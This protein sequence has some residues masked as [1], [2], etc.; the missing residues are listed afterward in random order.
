MTVQAGV[1]DHQI[2]DAVALAMRHWNIRGISF[3]PV[4]FFGRRPVAAPGT[5][6]RHAHGRPET[7]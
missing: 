4:A 7:N 5:G 6:P 3:Q 1:N 2:G